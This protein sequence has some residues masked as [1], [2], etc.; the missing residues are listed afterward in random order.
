MKRLIKAATENEVI[1]SS[2]YFDL[3]QRHGVGMQN[4]PYTSLEVISNGEAYKHVVSIRLE[5]K[6]EDFN[7]EEVHY[8][9]YPERTNISHGMRSSSDTLAETQEYIDVLE[10]ALEFVDTKLIPWFRKHPEWVAK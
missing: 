8:T 2:T 9:Y 6:W 3:V 4:T 5:S 10:S 1:L 7:G